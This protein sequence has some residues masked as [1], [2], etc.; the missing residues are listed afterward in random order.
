MLVIVGDERWLIFTQ[1]N[2]HGHNVCNRDDLSTTAI[3]GLNPL[4]PLCM[5]L[6]VGLGLEFSLLLHWL[7]VMHPYLY[8]CPLSLNVKVNR[9][10]DRS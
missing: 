7:V 4:M 5:R 3:C 10:D 1:C 6:L 9:E 2:C 8:F